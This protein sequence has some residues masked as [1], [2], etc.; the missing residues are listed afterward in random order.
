MAEIV[1]REVVIKRKRSMKQIYR[2]TGA[3]ENMEKSQRKYQILWPFSSFQVFFDEV[4]L[5]LG[6][7]CGSLIS[8]SEAQ[9][10]ELLIQKQK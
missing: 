4:I 2:S 1:V 3:I 10:S 7:L 9:V 8:E 6:W 5:S